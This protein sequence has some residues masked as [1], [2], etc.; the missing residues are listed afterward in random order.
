MDNNA[1]ILYQHGAVTES[2]AGVLVVAS[3]N[4]L[5]M[6]MSS[7]ASVSC[8]TN[9]GW[10][11]NWT[12]QCV[13]CTFPVATGTII[14]N[15]GGGDYT[16]QVDV[17][18]ASNAGS[19]NITTDYVGDAEPTGVGTGTYILGPYPSGTIVDVQVAHSSNPICTLD[20]GTFKDCCNGVC[21]GAAQAVIGTNTTPDLDCGAGASNL[22]TDEYG[23]STG[24]T[25]ARWFY[26]D[27]TQSGVLQAT[28]CASGIDTRVK[29]HDGTGG[30]GSLAPLAANDDDCFPSSTAGAFV[31]SGEHVLI[32]W[33]DRWSNSGFDWDLSL[34]PC[35]PDPNLDL[36][37]TQDPTAHPV[38][39]G[40][41]QT[42]TGNLDCLSPDD[43]VPNPFPNV[44]G[45]GWAAFQLT[46]CADVTIDYCGT[47]SFGDG[48][49]NMY[50]DCGNL[51]INSQSY[52]FTTCGDGNPT[53][54]FTN[55]AP[56][57]YY[58]PILWS[59]Y[60]GAVGAF[61]INVNAT[62]PSVACPTNL[63]ACAATPLNCLDDV[64][65]VTDNLFP[66]LPTNACPFPNGQ[67]GGSLWYSLTAA[68][69]EEV[70]LSTCGAGTTFN[71]RIS[72]FEGPDC[73]T[74]S[75]YTL[76]DDEGG[77]CNESPQLD[78]F[79]QG[80]PDLLDRRA[81][82]GLL[83]PRDLRA[84]RELQR[85]LCAPGQRRVQRRR[86]GL[87]LPG[88]WLGHLHQR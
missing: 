25:N 66:T 37:S 32:E 61:Q 31:S 41:G 47:A 23:P 17:T 46:E 64:F 80:G 15:C 48:A 40:S 8:S 22:G 2:L 85:R 27:A 78:F 12:V 13:D 51:F 58:Y 53:I 34:A 14:E 5:Y 3:G 36:C 82:P 68:S 9:V 28:S 87:Q 10:D 71:T 6:E 88:R 43:I 52:D 79:A 86:S 50:G 7:D 16:V 76:S 57:N 60:Y 67:S 42:W 33:D 84:D 45:W 30:C 69:D 26:Y 39:I 11:W 54:F 59:P 70:T 1:P 44:W 38:S 83:H 55:L 20:L 19:V 81:Q 75:C 63:T 29:L 56:G 72:V 73:N 18:D 65:G 74:L 62:T 4:S 77:A 35:T 49:L 24:G 21:S